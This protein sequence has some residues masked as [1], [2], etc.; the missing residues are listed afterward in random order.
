MLRNVA[1]RLREW[2]RNSARLGRCHKRRHTTLTSTCPADCEDY[3]STR[4]YSSQATWIL[5]LRAFCI[6]DEW[7]SYPLFWSEAT[8]GLRWADAAFAFTAAVLFVLAIVLARRREKAKWIARPT[9]STQLLLLLGVLGGLFG[10]RYADAY[11]FH[12]KNYVFSQIAH[13]VVL[14][15]VCTAVTLWSSRSQSSTSRQL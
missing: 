15:L 3:T 5:G 11:L 1:V 12:R 10:A 6:G 13:D 7:L 4:D 9:R 2:F 8:D 14:A